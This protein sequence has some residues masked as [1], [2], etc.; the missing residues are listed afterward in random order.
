MFA[1]TD[2]A[3]K[4]F[5]LS[6]NAIGD[7]TLSLRVSATRSAQQGIIYRMG[8]DKPNKEDI[9]CIISGI[10]VIVDKVSAQNVPAMIIVFRAFEGQ[11]QFVFLNPNE[12]KEDL[13]TSVAG[14]NPEAHQSC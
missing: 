1:I 7:E 14:C 5:Q 12:V 11:E 2:K 3:V 6:A 9:S 10:N 13:E 8:F 4:Q